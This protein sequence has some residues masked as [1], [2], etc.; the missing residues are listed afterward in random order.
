MCVEQEEAVYQGSGRE[1][2]FTSRGAGG[3]DFI[4]SPS[5]TD[6]GG[7]G[8]THR[9]GGARGNMDLWMSTQWVSVRVC[10]G[11]GGGVVMA[12]CAYGC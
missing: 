11:W 10:V 4:T 7:R 12:L 1:A 9:Q 2:G 6:G 5:L 3:R 8:R